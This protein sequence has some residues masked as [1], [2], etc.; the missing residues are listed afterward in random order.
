MPE[1]DLVVRHGTVID[2]SGGEPFEADV[3]VIGGRIA[4]S[5]AFP[6]SGSGKGAGRAAAP[7]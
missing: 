4:G 7:A 5:N 3:G 1:F 6:N 2:G